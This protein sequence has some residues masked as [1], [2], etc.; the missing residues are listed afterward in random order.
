MSYAVIGMQFGD[1]GKGLVTNYLCSLLKEK[2]PNVVRFSGGQQA[3]HT[4][5]HNDIVHTFSNFG[6]GTL[7]GVPTLWSELCSFDPV[8]TML[9]YKA[10]LSKGVNPVL[11]VNRNC[12]VTTPYD[13]LANRESKANVGHGTCGAGVGKTFERYSNHYSLSFEDLFFDK[14]LDIKLKLIGEYYND[15]TGV[16]LNSF[17][18]AVKDM[19]S[20]DI[21]PIDSLPETKR[22]IYEGSQGLL[23]DQEI[24][25]FPHVTRAYTGTKL[26]KDLSLHVFYVTRAYQTRHGNGP[27]TNTDIPH[28]IK[29][30][31]AE[32]NVYDHWQGEFRKSILDL[33]LLRYALQKD[34][35]GIAMKSL[36]ITCLDHV[37]NEHRFTDNNEIVCCETEREF[38]SEISERLGINDIYLSRTPYSDRL[39]RFRP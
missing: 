39:E 38:V 28:N 10:L 2:S 5:Y 34:S 16:D 13:V 30:N 24:G 33:D 23:L 4:V 32:T 19:R 37:E 3:G 7:Q 12:Q 22:L 25:F 6:S 17:V 26:L 9:E 21:R 27:M 20:C 18:D 11:R 1:E 29:P 36:V 15:V 31:P 8:S 35:V 14:I